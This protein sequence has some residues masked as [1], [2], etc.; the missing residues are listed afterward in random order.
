M[1]VMWFLRENDKDGLILL[2]LPSC[3]ENQRHP[4]TMTTS[5]ATTMTPITSMASS[6]TSSSEND[7]VPV[8]LP[9]TEGW[10]RQQ[11]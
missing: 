5:M 4:T 1:M 11:K 2:L 3:Y 10:Q 9:E 8:L 6:V 7:D